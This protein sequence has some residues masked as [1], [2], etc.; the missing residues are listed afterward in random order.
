MKSTLK[1][2]NLGSDVTQIPPSAFSGCENLGSVTSPRGCKIIGDFAFYG[3]SKLTTT[4]VLSG[5]YN[6]VRSIGNHA[7]D[8]CES[9]ASVNIANERQDNAKYEIGN[10]AFANCKNLKSVTLGGD[11]Q[12]LEK[13][14]FRD[15]LN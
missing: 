6:T 12:D 11:V 10:Y 8:G 14:C 3:C 7:F 2:V 5:G 13:E 4:S 1:S 9:I 15:A